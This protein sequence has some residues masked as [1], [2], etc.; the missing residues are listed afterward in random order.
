MNLIFLLT[1]KFIIN[2]SNFLVLLVLVN[3]FALIKKDICSRGN[4]SPFF[5]N[6]PIGIIKFNPILKMFIPAY[7]R[8]MSIRQFTSV[9]VNNCVKIIIRRRK[10]GFGFWILREV[11]FKIQ[12]FDRE[13]NECFHFLHGGSE[14]KSGDSGSKAR[15]G[16][17]KAFEVE[18]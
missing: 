13:I 6:S 18:D 1:G 3:V 8:I 2:L 11:F 10:G 9:M 14:W 7:A 15:R 17:P 12:W 16:C 4:N 5:D